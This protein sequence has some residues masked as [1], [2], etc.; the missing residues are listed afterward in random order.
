MTGCRAAGARVVQ[1]PADD[2]IAHRDT[3]GWCVS[4]RAVSQ[5][6]HARRFLCCLSLAVRV[7]GGRSSPGCARRRRPRFTQ[8]PRVVGGIEPV[9]M[10]TCVS[11]VPTRQLMR[12]R[13]SAA[14]RA[15]ALLSVVAAVAYWP[16]V[17]AVELATIETVLSPS[18]RWF[19]TLDLGG[20]YARILP[21][22]DR[23]NDC[24]RIIEHVTL[25]ATSDG[26]VIVAH[27]TIKMDSVQ[28]STTGP[29]ELKPETE[30][31]AV[32]VR[33]LLGDFNN[34]IEDSDISSLQSQIQRVL[35]GVEPA[36]RLC[37]SR[38]IPA[39]TTVVFFAEFEAITFKDLVLGAEFKYLALGNAAARLG[40]LYRARTN[41]LPVE[42]PPAIPSSMPTGVTPGG[43]PQNQN[44]GDPTVSPAPTTTP[45]ES[46]SE[47][48]GCF[49]LSARVTLESGTATD[50]GSLTVGSRVRVASSDAAVEHVHSDV[51]T[52]SHRRVDPAV[53][54]T[55]V[56]ITSTA[57]ASI[58]LTANHYM[59]VYG[60]SG[61]AP[62]LLTARSVKPGTSLVAADGSR[63]VVASVSTAVAAGLVNPHTLTGHLVVDGFEVSSY[64]ATLHPTLASAA[65]APVRWAYRAVGGRFDVTGGLLYHGAGRMSRFRWWPRGPLRV[66]NE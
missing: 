9:T 56:N 55:F 46:T 54:Y 60:A 51:F 64:T 38:T 59:H 26:G 50:V 1:T 49:P 47:D 35:R 53:K 43:G 14:M 21:T 30:I 6:R 3:A 58:L 18:V 42:S 28:C 25:P 66:V 17:G 12:A 62:S 5:P 65:L 33:A 22:Q 39:G 19:E 20:V 24:P 27:S 61:A 8:S 48:S 37:G 40:C 10:D 52:F 11:L 32:D 16:T 4:A 41:R 7:L 23:G 63:A 15:V 45:T 34:E 2:C 44:A 57:G 29:L 31:S 36:P 13:I